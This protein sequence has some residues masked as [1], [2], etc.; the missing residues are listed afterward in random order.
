MSEFNSSL[1]A[2]YGDFFFYSLKSKMDDDGGFL[3]H[4]KLQGT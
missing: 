3:W 4:Q 1:I 2:G